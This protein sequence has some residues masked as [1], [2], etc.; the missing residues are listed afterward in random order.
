[1]SSNLRH[2]HFPHSACYATRWN[3][4]LEGE[5]FPKIQNKS[6]NLDHMVMLLVILSEL[7]VDVVIV[8]R[9]RCRH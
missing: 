9:R 3:A 1:M 4:A 8:V 6:Q 5:G 2:H 7:M